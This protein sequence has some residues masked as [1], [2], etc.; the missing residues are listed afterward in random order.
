MLVRLA[1]GTLTTRFGQFSEV[2]YYD[3]LK[4]S[5]ALFMGDIAGKHDVLCRV[6]SSCISAHIFNSIECDCREQMEI[7]QFLI[8]QAGCGIIIWLDQ[9]GKGNGHMALLASAELRAQGLGQTDAYERLGY[10]RD[11]RSYT[12]AAEML[13]DLGVASINLLTNNPSKAD[14]L[15]KHAVQVTGCTRVAI[16]PSD[17]PILSKT[18]EDKIR[19]GHL[20]DLSTKPC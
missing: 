13:A 7:S 9:E 19:N 2:L 3:G 4:E 5:I 1:E 8:Q 16:D 11:A 15:V 12:R 6:H 17:N 18:Y 20:L 10:H 14:D